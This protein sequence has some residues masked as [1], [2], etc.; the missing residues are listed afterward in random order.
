METN[1][2]NIIGSLV[3]L[4]PNQHFNVAFYPYTKSWPP[5]ALSAMPTVTQT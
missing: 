1:N 2:I 4:I 5:N 3:S